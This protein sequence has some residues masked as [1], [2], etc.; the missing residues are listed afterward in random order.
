MR[1][2]QSV[3]KKII[4][5]SILLQI[6]LFIRIRNEKFCRKKKNNS[7]LKGQKVRQLAEL[8]A[9]GPERFSK[10]G[11]KPDEGPGKSDGKPKDV[12]RVQ[13]LKKSLGKVSSGRRPVDMVVMIVF[14]VIP[15]SSYRS[16]A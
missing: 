10:G 7:K 13:L 16:V 11:H 4:V 15:S 14:G 2:I 5:L 6:V 1:K 9:V 12:R 3:H 8:M